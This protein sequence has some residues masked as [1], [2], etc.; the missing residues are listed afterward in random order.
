MKA[1]IIY[2]SRAGENYG[3]DHPDRGN[4]EIVKDI[5][6]NLTGA[7]EFRVEPTVPYS[8]DYQPATEEA[9]NRRGN[10]PIE[11]PVPSLENYDTVIIM[12]PVFWGTMAPEMETALKGLDLTGKDVKVITTHEGSGLGSVVADVEKITTGAS[13]SDSLAVRG[14][15]AENSETAVKNWLGL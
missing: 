15:D 11:S 10:A 2:F 13:V 5:V 3:V 4:T 7:D 1:L 9:Q 8:L 12:T 6:K 14:A